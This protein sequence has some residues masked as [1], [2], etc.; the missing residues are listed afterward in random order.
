MNKNLS[1]IISLLLGLSFVSALTTDLTVQPIAPVNGNPGATVDVNLQIKNNGAS[2]INLVQVTSSQLVF[3]TNNI[4]APSATTV[5]SI[6]AGQTKTANLR[7][8]I[9][10]VLSGGYTGTASI[11][12]ASDT[13]NPA[14]DATYVVNVN[15]VDGIDV[16]TFTNTTPLTMTGQEDQVITS[17]FQIKNT[18]STAYTSRFTFNA[19]DFDSSCSV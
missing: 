2:T 4:S 18:G 9:P 6:A 8:T 15:A 1:I 19:A 7:V 17:T 10:N 3:G 11:K 14:L 5:A 12:D 13:T 16:L